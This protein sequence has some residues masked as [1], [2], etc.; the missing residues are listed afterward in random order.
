MNQAA[1]R[2]L[3]AFSLCLGATAC[4]P[5]AGEPAQ[6]TGTGSGG[7]AA[8]GAGGSGG[9]AAP[10]AGGSGG[11]PA[12]GAGGSGGS[13][14]G[15]G[16]ATGDASGVGGAPAPR[17]DGSVPADAASAVDQ[18]A[19]AADAAPPAVAIPPAGF[20]CPAGPFGDP[21]PANRVATL[22]KAQAGSL[23]GPV[24]VQGQ[25]A[26]YFC[27]V[28][29]V[30]GTG[31][32]DKYSVATRQITPFVTGVD[33]AGLALSP[34]GAIVATAFDK[35]ML[36]EF[37]PVSGKRTDIAGSNMYMGKPLNQTNDLVVRSDGNIYFTDTDYR[38][39]G[40]AG[41]ETTAHYRFSPTGQITRTGAGPE[42]NGI[43]LSPDGRTLYVSSTG[44][45]PLR[46]FT[47]DDG[48]A[49]MGAPVTFSPSSSDGMAVDCAGN[50]YLSTAG[51][52]RVISP[53]GTVLGSITGLGTSTV[54]NAAFGGPD[55]KTLF[56]TT[57]SAL[58]QITLNIP[59]FPS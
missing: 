52:I 33:V 22:I 50:V 11:S 36:S 49:V 23:E 14:A 10:G 31:R 2:W 12:P 40:R 19:P 34:K 42:P 54:S 24:W 17:A 4:S 44:G 39:D 8:P 46:K 3:L 53:A 30:A 6:T 35:R 29:P 47:L 7:S 56:I 59:G 20:T 58:Y 43:A 38:Q 15:P 13:P 26:L 25:N 48:G 41:Q 27:V 45:D 37:D 28:G 5:V 1:S 51:T 32:I 16:P 9:S 18:A 21:L 57:A 55:H